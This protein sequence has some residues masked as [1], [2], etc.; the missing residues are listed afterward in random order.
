[1]LYNRELAL[2]EEY[3]ETKSWCG[4]QNLQQE[5]HKSQGLFSRATHAEGVD[6]KN[7]CSEL[8]QR[9]PARQVGLDGQLK[10]N[11][12]TIEKDEHILYREH[13]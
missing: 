2:Q 6:E 1:M 7:C 12:D 4:T 5:H 11:V 9:S 8:V 10:R 3:R 13:F